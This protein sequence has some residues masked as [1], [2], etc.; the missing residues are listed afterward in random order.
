MSVFPLQ[1]EFQN[2]IVLSQHIVYLPIPKTDYYKL[3]NDIE[4]YK[5]QIDELTI[6][7]NKLKQ[8]NFKLLRKF[9]DKKDDGILKINSAMELFDLLHKLENPDVMTD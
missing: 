3:I 7:I 2:N 1:L 8:K 5:K 4:D 6:G 9:K